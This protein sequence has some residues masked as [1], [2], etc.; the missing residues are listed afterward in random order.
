M[1]HTHLSTR[2]TRRRRT[3][4]LHHER[5][6]SSSK[7]H[8]LHEQFIVS[9]DRQRRM[10]TQHCWHR[11]FPLTTKLCLHENNQ[12]I[13]NRAVVLR[14]VCI[15]HHYNGQVFHRCLSLKKTDTLDNIL[16]KTRWFVSFPIGQNLLVSDGTPLFIVHR[17]RWLSMERVD[18]YQSMIQ[19]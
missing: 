15:R 1:S 7:R 19:F 13:L 9:L 5:S 17:T 10:N 16:T 11:V 14:F 18:R 2:I 12:H 8:V 3:Y 6:R 4:D